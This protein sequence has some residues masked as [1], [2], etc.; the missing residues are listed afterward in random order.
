MSPKPV[1]GGLTGIADM[2]DSTGI[3]KGRTMQMHSG[4]HLV[5]ALAAITLG[6]SDALMA[7][8]ASLSKSPVALAV[9]HG[10]CADAVKLV[11]R[12][13][14]LNDGQSV[15]IAGR[16]LDEG[17]C[18]E[19]N[20]A[21]ATKFFAH[22]ADMGGQAAQLDYAAKIG[23]GEGTAQDYAVAGGQCRTAGLDPE[24]HVSDY[25]LGFVCT[26]RGLT[27][28]LLRE[29]LPT[30]AFQTTAGAHAR[31]EFN[32]AKGQLF[33]RA[34]TS[35]TLGE[36]TVSSRIGL[37]LVNIKQEVEKAWHKALAKAPKPDAT[38]LEDQLVEVILDLD[39]TMEQSTNSAQRR[40]AEDIRP[41]Q[42]WDMLHSSMPTQQ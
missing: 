35:V 41:L 5:L 18:V 6:A 40:S 12:D 39:M 27:S 31:L 14:E 37:P 22:A 13:V 1:R 38:R 32:P 23:L 8:E 11:K 26:M 21:V 24:K 34:A 42:T 4:R 28:R 3:S 36:P 25:S 2:A 15:F 33:V 16:M 17:L 29:S 9:A 7:T 30:D 20:S 19:R 10:E